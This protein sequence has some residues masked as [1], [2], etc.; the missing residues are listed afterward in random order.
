M[1]IC[2]EIAR[3][4]LDQSSRKATIDIIGELLAR[5]RLLQYGITIE[6]SPCGSGLVA[7]KWNRARSMQIR[8]NIRERL[9]IQKNENCDLVAIV[10]LDAIVTHARIDDPFPFKR[11]NLEKSSI[12]LIESSQLSGCR[13]H[14]V[15]FAISPKL[16]ERYFHPEQNESS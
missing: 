15:D 4:I 16:V 11:L 1:V 6:E 13:N 9:R 12:Y 5:I 14:L 8:T 10:S 3:T 2:P 7:R